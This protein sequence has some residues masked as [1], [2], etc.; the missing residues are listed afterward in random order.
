[1]ADINLRQPNK[2]TKT[3]KQRITECHAP[4]AR[5]HAIKNPNGGLS[6][7]HITQFAYKG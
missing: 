5:T 6:E 1:M 3:T 4:R 7:C 2:N